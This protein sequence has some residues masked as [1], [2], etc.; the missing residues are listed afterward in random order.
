MHG[1]CKTLVEW[2]VGLFF[3]GADNFFDI[4]FDKHLYLYQVQ[5]HIFKKI[6]SRSGTYYLLPLYDQY[7]VHVPYIHINKLIHS[8]R[9]CIIV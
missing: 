4:F 6:Y 2:F 5:V 1:R 9:R 7:P 8:N 3:E